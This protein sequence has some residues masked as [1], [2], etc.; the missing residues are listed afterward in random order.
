MPRSDNTAQLAEKYDLKDLEP[1]VDPEKAAAFLA[2]GKGEEGKVRVTRK[3]TSESQQSKPRILR[4]DPRPQQSHFT[5]A[6]VSEHWTSR[7]IRLRQST[8]V[9]L[10]M[11]ACGQKSRQVETKVSPGE[12]V[13][14]QEIADFGIR[15]A[16]AQLGYQK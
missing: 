7:T 12:P 13:T 4:T 9:A 1:D 6:A 11:A 16:L 3:R 8:A 15:L 5:S 2:S 10:T 14:V